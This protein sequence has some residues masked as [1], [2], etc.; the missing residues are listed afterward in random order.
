M[1]EYDLSTLSGLL[2]TV[3]LLISQVLR[4]NPQAY[5]AFMAVPDNWKL[6]LTIVTVAGISYALGQSV[7]LFANQVTRG[8]FVFSLI[9][10]AFTLAIG[11]IFWTFSIWLLAE[12]LFGGR[13]A[14]STVLAAVSISFAPYLFGFLILIPY[15]GNIIFHILRIWV[16]LAV[17]VGVQVTFQ[18]GFWEA[19][20]CSV[21]GWVLLE[22]IARLPF[23]RIDRIDG[24][25]WRITTGKQYQ[26]QTGEIVGLYVDEE[27]S[28][29][30]G[31][32]GE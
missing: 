19:M 13:Q 30:L 21:I 27:R 16:L 9:V 1:P 28:S 18:F 25:V 24:W 10:S 15:L 31:E 11:A 12:I 29:T 3:W 17:I 22:L 20:A 6:A 5:E 32:G 26:L 14:F 8:H 7:V 4:L 2:S 23:L